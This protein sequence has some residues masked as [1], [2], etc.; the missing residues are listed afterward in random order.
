MRLHTAAIVGSK[1]G[2]SKWSPEVA[3]MAYDAGYAAACAGFAVLTGGLSGV[4]T[5]AARGAREA[6]GMAIGLLPGTAHADGNEH[7]TIVL[8]TSIGL[9]RN[10]LVAL[11]C[12]VMVALPGG[13]G[14]LQEMSYAL[15]YKRPVFSWD[16]WE[17]PGVDHVAVRLGSMRVET[18]LQNHAA[19]LGVT[20]GK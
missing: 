15:E 17:L 16:S 8:P 3:K 13:L 9:A 7:L 20:N 12:D 1:V 11:G 2:G 5:E 19:R 10:V 14:T 18:W 4:M 6:G